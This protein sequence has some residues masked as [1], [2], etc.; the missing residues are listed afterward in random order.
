MKIL[1]IKSK[2]EKN[3]IS[4]IYAKY[5]GIGVKNIQEIDTIRLEFNLKGFMNDITN[6]IH[7]EDIKLSDFEEKGKILFN[8]FFPGDL[9]KEIIQ[10]KFDIFIIQS[11][12]NLIPWE[13]VYFKDD[14][15]CRKFNLVRLVTDE[16]PNLIDK[17]KIVN[18]KIIK[19]IL[20]IDA[21]QPENTGVAEGLNIRKELSREKKFTVKYKS[22]NTPNQFF[23]TFVEKFDLFHLAIEVMTYD[24][25]DYLSAKYHSNSPD[26]LI[27]FESI[28]KLK[29]EKKPVIFSTG[30]RSG[31]N[32]YATSFIRAN[33][34]LYIAPIMD[35]YWDS[36]AHFA[37]SLYKKIA[38]KTNILSNLKTAKKEMRSENDTI[39][40]LLYTA[41][42]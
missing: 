19:T 4:I 41:F 18:E 28:A 21:Q 1:L 9:S 22:I 11:E 24:G 27:P 10:E 6:D 31:Y 12:E 8:L 15:L 26:T 7:K 3:N 25:L 23:E 32:K 35:V 20:I 13:L 38:Q 37:A 2:E 29:L 40:A 17:I 30:C 33:C 5:D 42:M 16:L 14:F 36:S 39:M 34:G